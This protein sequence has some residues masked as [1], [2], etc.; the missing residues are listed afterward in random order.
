M[1]ADQPADHRGLGLTQL[2]EFRGDVCDRTVVLTELAAAGQA[3]SRRSVTLAGQRSGQGLGPVEPV[4][5]DDADGLRTAVLEPGQLILGECGDRLG[6]SAASQVPQ[7]GHR[8]IVVG[9]RKTFP[10]GAGEGELPSRTTPTA[11]GPVRCG[12]TL[13]PSLGFQSVEVAAHC[14]GRDAEFGGQIGGA[15]RPLAPEQ[16]DHPIAG[17]AVIGAGPAEARSQRRDLCSRGQ[18]SGFHN[19]S[20]TYFLR[21]FHQGKPNLAWRCSLRP[22]A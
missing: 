1:R 8:Q 15:Q 12:A 11:A 5:P 10:A 19:N 14:C 20:V 3:R 18:D 17:T 9:M 16:V 21:S 13:D 7:S 2:R 6:A 4:G 22:A